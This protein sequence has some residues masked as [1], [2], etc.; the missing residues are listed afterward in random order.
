[1]KSLAWHQRVD[2]RGRV[3]RVSCQGSLVI[4]YLHPAPSNYAVQGLE[5]LLGAR[6]HLR[7]RHRSALCPLLRTAALHGVARSFGVHP[8][9]VPAKP[10]C[11]TDDQAGWVWGVQERLEREYNLNLIITAPSV[12]YKVHKADGSILEVDNPAQLPP[13]EKRAFIEE[14]YVRVS[15]IT[16][17]RQTTP[18]LG[19]TCS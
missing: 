12:V 11:S 8:E 1:V 4:V 2:I 18:I 6:L 9:P 15:S 10:Q 3:S 14:P 17:S 13:A 5:T 19:C 7:H 16:A